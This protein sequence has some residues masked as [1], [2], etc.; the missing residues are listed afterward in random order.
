M[1]HFVL[2]FM[3]LEN[4]KEIIWNVLK[5]FDIV[6]DAFEVIYV[7]E[8]GSNLISILTGEAH[9]HCI[10][11]CINLFVKQ[12][13]EEWQVINSSVSECRELVPHFRRMI[14]ASLILPLQ[15]L[16]LM[17]TAASSFCMKQMKE[18]DAKIFC[19]FFIIEKKAMVRDLFSSHIF[20][21]SINW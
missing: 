5:S 12:S 15:A 7:T 20:A 8:N 21:P 1:F 10:C 17:K 2:K 4:K 13:L 3:I 9:I 14:G 16:F 6:A 19:V 11:H 18:K